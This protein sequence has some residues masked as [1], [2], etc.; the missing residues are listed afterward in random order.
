MSKLAYIDPH[1]KGFMRKHW[2]GYDIWMDRLPTSHKDSSLDE[3]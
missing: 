3:S 1:V 2:Q